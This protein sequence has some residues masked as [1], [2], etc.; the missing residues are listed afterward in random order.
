MLHRWKIFLSL[1]FVLA[2]CATTS[3]LP[4]AIDR[5]TATPE[6]HGAIWG[7]DVQDES[8]R[9]LYERNAHTLLMPASNRKLFSSS[10][11]IECFGLDHQFATELWLDG[12]NVVVRG[13]ADPSLGALGLS[14]V[15]QP[16]VDALRARGIHSVDDVI[17][18]VSAFDRDTIPGTW[19]FGN[20]G[21]DYAAPV[22]ALAFNENSWDDGAAIDNPGLFAAQEFRDALRDSGI[23]VHGT[24]WVNTIP[25]P[26][27]ERIAVIESPMM[28]QLVARMLKVSQNLYAEMLFKATDGTYGGAE[29]KER[30]F[31]TN[32]VHIDGS[33][34]RFVDGCGLSP[35]DLVTPA[36]VVQLLRWMNSRHFFWDLLATPG[37]EG[38]LHR[39]LTP[40]ATR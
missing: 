24:A 5:V 19:K 18:D 35:D 7:I 38:T 26:W 33:E 11:A 14:G 16:F 34:F 1:S 10:T 17:A 37:E 39:R 27:Q 6:L 30:D 9:V 40:L 23:E 13:N 29:A 3:T 8:G 22:D 4:S 2:G 20:L 21:S 36:A 32:E 15:F 31:L 25:H 28:S 12:S